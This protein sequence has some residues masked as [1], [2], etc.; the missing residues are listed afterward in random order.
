M[1]KI[2]W[3][4]VKSEYITTTISQR[5]LADKYKIS[6]STLTKR[7]NKEK[8]QQL[9][10]TNNNE[11]A[12]K[13]QQKTVAKIITKEVNRLDKI[14]SASDTLLNKLVA[15]TGD[16]VDGK[17]IKQLTS[18]LKDLKDIQAVAVTT[19]TTEPS[20]LFQALESEDE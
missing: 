9:R 2:D 19:A 6:A 1:M 18:A 10:E 8:W 4:R 12:T 15:V 14:L 5:D 7:A 17:G 16:T 3:L 13:V 11:I 20:S